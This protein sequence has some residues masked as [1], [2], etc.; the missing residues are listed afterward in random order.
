[1][2]RILPV[3]SAALIGLMGMQG[4]AAWAA[5]PYEPFVEKA[6]TAERSRQLKV[7]LHAD[8]W[9]MYDMPTAELYLAWKG[10]AKGGVLEDA[11]YWY[12]ANY[13]HFPHWFKTS[14]VEYFRE[15]VGEFFSDWAPAADIPLYY[16]KWPKQPLN[17]KNWSV[18]SGGADVFAHVANHGYFVKGDVFKF[19]NGLKLK[20]GGEIDVMEIPDYDGAGGKT[21]LVR[22]I[23][24][25]GIPAGAEVR[26]A[27]PKGGNWTVSGKGTLQGSA[28]VQTADGESIVTGTW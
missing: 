2:H 15:S 11:V 16:T 6:V 28:L 13:G 20:G 7:A 8:L 26:L 5:R 18:T 9:V 14:G 25:T 10:G 21:N 22:K 4:S 19:H 23:T 12:G 27:L 3:A 24:F 1:M 17:Y